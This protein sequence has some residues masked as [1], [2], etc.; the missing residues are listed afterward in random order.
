MRELLVVL[1]MALAAMSAKADPYYQHAVLTPSSIQGELFTGMVK[2]NAGYAQETAL[3]LL[4]HNYS[5]EDPW[6]KPSHALLAVGYSAG[7]GSAFANLGPVLDVGPQL[8]YGI[9]WVAAAANASFGASTQAF[10]NCSAGAT[11]CGQLSAGVMANGTF[12]ENGQLVRTWH[13][14][15]AH[16]VA[17]FV[18]PTILFK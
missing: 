15:G 9:E 3:P 10:F 14:F 7:G 17:Y 13:E 16:P 18:G 1:M 2:T 8:T 12:E 6:Y 11:A 4:Y 5:P